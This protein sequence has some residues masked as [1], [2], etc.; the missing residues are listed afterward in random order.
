MLARV[1][2]RTFLVNCW[3]GICSVGAVFG[4]LRGCWSRL[5]FI[6]KSLLHVEAS[7][8]GIRGVEGR[9]V[10]NTAVWF[11]AAVGRG[12]VFFQMAL[13]ETVETKMQTL[14]MLYSIL[15]GRFEILRIA[16]DRMMLV[17]ERTFVL[18]L[19][20]IL[21]G[22]RWCRERDWWFVWS[23]EVRFN[24]FENSGLNL[25]PLLKIKQSRRKDVVLDGVF[26][27]FENEIM[28]KFLFSNSE[29][30]WWLKVGGESEVD[31]CLD[32]LF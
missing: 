26:Y 10:Q 19:L 14:N 31:E 16:S 6:R 7:V 23:R 20:G 29:Y 30:C 4:S 18:F 11:E 5:W 8:S 9:V 2:V 3:G 21:Q 24:S 15:D 32:E 25:Q 27:P 22:R 17:T 12:A 13:T 1:V 28:R